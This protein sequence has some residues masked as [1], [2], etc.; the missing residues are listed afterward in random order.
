MEEKHEVNLQSSGLE[1][2]E[3]DV[4][5]PR[6]NSRHRADLED[7]EPLRELK[8]CDLCKHQSIDRFLCGANGDRNKFRRRRR[9]VLSADERF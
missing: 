3:K 6:Q 1:D 9:E 7:G 4:R 2:P 5:P 8:C